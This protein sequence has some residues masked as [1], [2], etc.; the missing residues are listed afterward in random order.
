LRLEESG[1]VFVVFRRTSQLVGS[2]VSVTRNGQPVLVPSHPPVIKIQSATYGVPGDAA[3]T[4]DVQGKLQALVD[5]G[6]AVF[7]VARMAEGDDS[8]YGTVKTLMVQYTA[9]ERPLT[10]SGHD[11][12]T[13]RLVDPVPAP[14][15]AAEVR[16]DSAG[17]LQL[18]ASQ[19]GDYTLQTS[20]GQTLHATIASIPSPLVLDGP[21][22]VS[23]PPHW[24]APALI[25]MDPLASLSD[26]TNAGVKYFSGT[27][28]YARTFD[29]QPASNSH[30]HRAEVWLDLG[31]V[32]VMARV[33]LNGH[34]LGILWKP[35][36]RINISGALQP[37]AN[38]LEIRV[39]D[40][41]PNRMI[42]DA[43][44]PESQRLTWSTYEP[45]NADT[46]LLPSGLLGPVSLQFTTLTTLP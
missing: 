24:G 4:R 21:W 29:W 38:S 3:R 18:L 40:L 16:T 28:T 37:G 33:K 23:F 17:H 15:P 45:F 25:T 13:V 7:Q 36:F 2:I 31:N 6:E 32:Q 1:S 27:A 26:S 43:A 19:P 44:L 11:P 22:T 12:D 39:A 10:L 42:G 5:R 9:D 14:S 30:D 20:V 34:D 35:P 41:W 46:P 8:A